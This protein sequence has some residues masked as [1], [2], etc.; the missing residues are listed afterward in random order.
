M[1]IE[2]LEVSPF[3]SNCYIVGSESTKE[4]IVIDTGGEADR[5][6]SRIKGLGLKIKYIVLTHA[7]VD[8]IAAVK[9]VKAGTGAGIAIHAED[10]KLLQSRS[11]DGAMFRLAWQEPPT[12]DRLLKGGDSIE[13]GELKFLVLHTPGHT[14]GG[15]CLFGEGVVFSGDTLFFFGIGRTDGPTGNYDQII[16]SIQTKLMVLPEKT[17]VYPGHGPQTT[18]GMERRG[19]PF[20]GTLS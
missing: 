13:I 6:L 1:I 16:A 11:S 2:K 14:Q 8:H 4:A 20:V 5:I 17:V 3:A 15:I 10:A 12:P 9:E 18:I 19:N 7:H